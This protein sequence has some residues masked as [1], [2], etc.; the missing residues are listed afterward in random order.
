MNKRGFTTI[1][2]VLSFALVAIIL[3]SL[4]GLVTSYSDKLMNEQIKTQLWDYKNTVTKAIYDDIV[5]RNYISLERCNLDDVDT[6]SQQSI[7][8][9]SAKSQGETKYNFQYNEV[10]CVKFIDKYGHNTYL[11]AAFNK[12]NSTKHS[13][14]FMEY[15]GT[16]YELPDSDLNSCTYANREECLVYFKDFIFSSSTA[17]GKYVEN[18]KI[19]YYHRDIDEEFTIQVTLQEN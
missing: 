9:E 17:N 2:L 14:F 11:A 15:N 1:E 12:V 16:L 8:R 13:P 4:V 18:V 3:L 10:Y 7:I 19:P 5:V 6:L